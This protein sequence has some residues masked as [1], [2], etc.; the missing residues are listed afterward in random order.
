MSR[1]CRANRKSDHLTV[2]S[3]M[4]P[5]HPVWDQPHWQVSH[6]Q[7]LQFVPQAHCPAEHLQQVQAPSQT[8]TAEFRML[9]SVAIWFVF[10]ILIIPLI[11]QKILPVFPDKTSVEPVL[12]YR[13]K[14]FF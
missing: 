5:K 7:Q 9:V 2:N 4:L 8:D 6:L 10:F 14:Y 12:D 11:S 1:G 3:R 13:V